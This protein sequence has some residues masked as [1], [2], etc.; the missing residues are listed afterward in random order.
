MMSV[1]VVLAHPPPA[2]GQAPFGDVAAPA[3]RAREGAGPDQEGLAYRDHTGGGLPGAS[4][5]L[6]HHALLEQRV[7]GNPHSANPA[8]L[9]SS[10]LVA[11][12]RRDILR[13]LGASPDEYVVVFTPNAS[14]A[15]K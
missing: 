9:R 6:E 12:A 7:F 4:Q 5:L 10:E 1:A 3:P 14:G 15:C 11:D 13:F 2:T 8:S